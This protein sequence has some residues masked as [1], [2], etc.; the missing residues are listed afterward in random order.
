MKPTL[1]RQREASFFSHRNEIA[2]MTQLHAQPILSRYDI[3]STK[4]F[5]FAPALPRSL[6]TK[7]I[8]RGASPQ[9]SRVEP[10]SKAFQQYPASLQEKFHDRPR[11]PDHGRLDRYWSCSRLGL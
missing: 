9:A 10:P 1:G 6:V 5:S 7:V 8:R 2:Q 3:D 11:C 4:S